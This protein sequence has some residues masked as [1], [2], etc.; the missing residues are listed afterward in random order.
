MSNPSRTPNRL[1][2]EK[3][4]YLLQH[5]YNPVDWYPWGEE[6]FARA[7]EEDKPVFLSVGYST[8][9]WCHVMERESFEDEETAKI[10]NESFVA[11]KVDKEERPDIDAVYMAV[12][13]AMTGSGGWPM[14]VIMSPDQKP[15]FA[16]TYFPKESRYG[17]PGLNDILAAV[18]E[19]WRNGRAELLRSG[20]EILR[21]LGRAAAGKSP[22]SMSRE[23]M[24]KAKAA[25]E[26]EFDPLYGGFGSAPKFPSP[27]NILFLLRYA[28]FEKDGKAKAMAEKTLEQMF[29]GGI[30]DHVGG[31]FSR[32][33]TD[34]KWLAPHFEKMLYDNA[35]L[36][37][38][39]TEAYQATGR[40]L[41]R[42]TAE[43][44][45][46]YV[47][48][49]LTHERGGFFCAF[50]AD[51]DGVEGKYYLLTPEETREALGEADSIYFNRYYGITA[52]GNFEGRNIPNLLDK[53]DIDKPDP[54][55]ESLNEKIAA[56]RL[57]RTTLHRDDKIL[58]SWNA[59]MITALAKAARVF[60]NGAY[61]RAAQRAMD[62][63]RGELSDGAGELKVRWRGGEAAGNGYLDD[64]AFTIWALLSLYEASW[65]AGRLGQALEYAK[66]MIDGFEDKENGGYYL[67][68][69]GSEQLISRPKETY[70][71][72][73]PSGNSMAGFVL[74]KL[75]ALT[76]DPGLAEAAARQLDF[77]AGEAARYP[78]GFTFALTAGMAQVYPGAEI[79]CVTEKDAPGE[80]FRKLTGGLYLPNT[81]VL[82]KDAANAAALESTAPLKA[83]NRAIRS[84]ETYY[85][86]ENRA[87]L[88]AFTDIGELEKIL[89]GK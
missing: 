22:R 18:S 13:Q 12:C 60:E 29:R 83:S 30:F 28:L 15:F 61:L 71:G 44:I 21:A 59:M 75:A 88:P 73:V 56:Y 31:G 69:A 4:P 42:H 89:T 35:F 70:D 58:T 6:A 65:D 33:S 39:Y 74:Q 78:A 38:A 24:L 76:G 84:R 46:G 7:R 54:I 62:F 16:G 72:A 87:C 50:D 25:L 82:V 41:Y 68:A 36:T 14:T 81:T 86:C 52:T 40:M 8:C 57:G 26:R 48:R 1:M 11:V 55:I 23:L 5:A 80:A 19:K 77:L 66:R 32:Y 27:H 51:S 64:Y 17:M 2:N 85:V 47:L 20:D 3:S 67:Y 43:R 34:N 63:V 53:K 79:V 49:E 9:H 45:I 10:L 37:V